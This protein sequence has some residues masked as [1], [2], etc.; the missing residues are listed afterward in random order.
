MLKFQVCGAVHFKE[1]YLCHHVPLYSSLAIQMLS[2]LLAHLPAGPEVISGSRQPERVRWLDFTANNTRLSA[3]DYKDT[4]AFD[5]YIQTELLDDGS[6]IGVGGYDEH[7]VLYA[8]ST[9]FGTAHE[10]PRCIHL[11]IDLW[12]PA[13]T[14]VIAPLPGVLHSFA[15]N[16]HFGDY[17]PTLILQHTIEG[18]T[19]Y[20]LYGH[21]SRSS[22]LN[23]SIGQPFEAGQPIATVGPWPENGHWPPHLHFQLMES[24]GEAT[25]DYPGVCTLSDRAAYLANCPDPNL[26][27]RIPKE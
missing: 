10:E 21:L 17:G 19:F 2:N 20:T 11:G 27:L 16:D 18:H 15:D 13:G 26:L 12:V 22:L 25:G 8:R 6:K 9:H 1:L 14:P 3:V 4:A 23:L 7:R 5:R 24:L